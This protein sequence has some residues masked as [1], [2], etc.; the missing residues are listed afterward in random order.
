M[1]SNSEITNQLRVT[2]RIYSSIFTGL[3]LFLIVVIIIIRDSNAEGGNNLDKIFTV[4]VPLFGLLIMVI[5]KLV[6]NRMISGY[7]SETDLVKKIMR[8]RTSK[9]ISW[10]MVEAA[11][12]FALIATMLTSNYLYVVVVIFLLGYL[13]MLKPSKE[14]LIRDFQ[15]NSAESD[16]VLKN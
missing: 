5:S 14:S 16:I 10:A 11:C 6:Y 13:F 4:I 8:Y 2:K 9:I 12:F 7:L 3:I 1:S 15:L